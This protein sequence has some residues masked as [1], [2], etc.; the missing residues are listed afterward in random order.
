MNQ[1]RI[2]ARHLVELGFLEEILI[3]MGYATQLVERSPQVPYHVLLVGLESDSGG[4]P[5]QMAL[6]FYPVGEDEVE[7]TMLLQYFIELP[8]EVD[9]GGLARLREL[10][11]DINNK[12][13]LGH[14]G[15]TVGQNKLHYRYVQALPVDRLISH[16]AVSDVIVLVTYT[17]RLFEEMV[18]DLAGGTISVE[19]ARARLDAQYADG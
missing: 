5:L 17:P 11:P 16:G 4:Q 14:L 2:H 13:V 3:D 18:Q 15:I 6:T 10:L 8:F 9:E 1:E 12:I 19:Q 7:N